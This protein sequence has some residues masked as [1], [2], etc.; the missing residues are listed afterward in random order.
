LLESGSK[1][2]NIGYILNW[3][4]AQRL[5]DCRHLRKVLFSVSGYPLLQRYWNMCSLD[6][7]HCDF[8]GRR[9]KFDTRCK[10]GTLR[11]VWVCP[12][13]VDL[14]FL[15]GEN[16]SSCLNRKVVGV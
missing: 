8:R 10:I 14:S 6:G 7:K 11:V 4:S 15:K 1:T 12:K 9:L 5:R 3:K 16:P 2:Y 13:I